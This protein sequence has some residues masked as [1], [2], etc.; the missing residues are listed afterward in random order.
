MV[1]ILTIIFVHIRLKAKNT[2][3]LLYKIDKR[4]FFDIGNGHINNNKGIIKYLGRY[5]AR[6]PIAEYKISSISHDSVSFF[7]YDLKLNKK[8]TFVTM[9][10]SKFIT[11]ILIHLPPKNFK[12][13]S[14]FG[15]YARRKSQKLTKAMKTFKTPAVS[16]NFSWYERQM[17]NTFN[18]NP[19]VC[20]KCNIKMKVS[21]FYHHLY[22][23]TRIYI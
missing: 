6:A 15:F 4:F 19:F 17:F 10:L 18:I 5:L 9:P 12:M 14:R 22:P 16:S 21:E 3:N 2:V 7:F 23:P 1:N 20:P 8:K 11:Q 13:I